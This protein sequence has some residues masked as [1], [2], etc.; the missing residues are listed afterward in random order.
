MGVLVLVVGVGACGIPIG[1]PAGA[2][3]LKCVE[4]GSVEPPTPEE[5]ARGWYE[6]PPTDNI[7]FEV[8]PTPAEQARF[9]PTAPRADDWRVASV[10]ASAA[11][12]AARAS[13][14]LIVTGGL[15][16]ATRSH[17]VAYMR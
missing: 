12:T 17:C 8:P 14:R 4:F 9:K 13:S 7:C 5:E 3:E 6:R 16:S 15:P 2:V 11:A 1:P 10:A